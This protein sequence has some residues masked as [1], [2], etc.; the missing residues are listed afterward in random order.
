M[1]P[2]VA[3]ALALFVGYA[4]VVLPLYRT[5]RWPR[6]TDDGHD[7]VRRMMP[8]RATGYLALGGVLLLMPGISAANLGLA[9]PAERSWVPATGI[10]VG[11]VAVAVV[12]GLRRWVADT[13]SGWYAEWD[14][15]ARRRGVRH[16]ILGCLGDTAVY[17]VVPPLV[18]VGALGLPLGHVATAMV[19]GYGLVHL[20]M[21]VR[22]V[23]GWT[24]VSA[25]AVATYL[26]T[27]SALL[28]A[29]LVTAVAVTDIYAV[30]MLPNEPPPSLPPPLTLVEDPAPPLRGEG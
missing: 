26:M 28:P 20:P 16:T 21:G 13:E 30:P 24:A 1:H 11:A 8:W 9:L 19:V 18:G 25:V 12:L 5:W 4:T 27:G 22:A 10:T 6:L 3:W 17:F 7:R 2:A 15:A 23:L 14:E 29:V